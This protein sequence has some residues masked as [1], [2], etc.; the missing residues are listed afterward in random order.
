[1][2]AIEDTTN[3]LRGVGDRVR[4]MGERLRGVG[5]RLR[6]E[7]ER[8]EKPV[9]YGTTVCRAICFVAGA[10]V[11]AYTY[12]LNPGHSVGLGWGVLAAMLL[13]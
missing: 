13:F 8:V 6:G 5:E 1:M 7:T 4:G 3:E 10:V 9:W 12:K 11:E 2:A